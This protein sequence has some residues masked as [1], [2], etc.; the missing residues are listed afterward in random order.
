[1]EREQK[2]RRKVEGEM[3]VGN[4]GS[5]VTSVTA[6]NMAKKIRDAS[7]KDGGTCSNRRN[8]KNKCS[9]S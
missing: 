3:G 8:R 2:R 4:T 7:T 9:S 6:S 5:K 1:L